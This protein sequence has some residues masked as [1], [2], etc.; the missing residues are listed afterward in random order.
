VVV[1]PGPNVVDLMLAALR[2]E[3]AAQPDKPLTVL[4]RDV[5]DS[6]RAR[7]DPI[8]TAALRGTGQAVLDREGTSEGDD[9]AFLGFLAIARERPRADHA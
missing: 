9:L 7:V 3:R 1:I 4:V 5:W 8:A 6:H 2:R